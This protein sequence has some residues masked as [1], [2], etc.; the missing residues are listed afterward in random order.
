MT[1]NASLQTRRQ[2]AFPRGIGTAFPVFAQ[3]AEGSE[4]WDVE[5]K[6]WSARRGA[7]TLPRLPIFAAPARWRRSILWTRMAAPMRQRP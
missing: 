6:R 1:D 7:M 5:G 3:R 2:T 4:L